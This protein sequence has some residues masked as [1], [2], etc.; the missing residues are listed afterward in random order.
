MDNLWNRFFGEA[1]LT[2]EFAEEC[3]PAGVQAHK[4]EATFD[5]GTLRITLP[6]VL[7]LLYPSGHGELSN[8]DMCGSWQ[9]R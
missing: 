4:V 6:G 9:R 8:L 7:F 1:P 2:R 5:K 3:W